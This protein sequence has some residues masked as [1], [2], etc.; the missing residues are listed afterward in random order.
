MLVIFMYEYH[1]EIEEKKI[2]NVGE[3]KII[4][5]PRYITFDSSIYYDKGLDHESCMINAFIM[6]VINSILEKEE[7]EEIDKYLVDFNLPDDQVFI[8]LEKYIYNQM[9]EIFAASNNPRESAISLLKQLKYIVPGE[10][11][12]KITGAR[13]MTDLMVTLFLNDKIYPLYT[14]KSITTSKTNIYETFYNYLIMEYKINK[15]PKLVFDGN[16]FFMDLS[17]C[18]HMS[19]KEERLRKEIKTIKKTPYDERHK[20]LI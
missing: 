14:K 16:N 10:N 6:N 4:V 15:C 11:I 7:I 2:I 9:K 13:K 12:I 19:D 20:Y 3:E 17:T 1:K 5:Y 8:S 18:Y